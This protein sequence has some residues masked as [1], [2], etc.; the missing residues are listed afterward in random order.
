MIG[1]ACFAA[2]TLLAARS[3]PQFGGSNLHSGGLNNFV[4]DRMQKKKFRR[5][6]FCIF[7]VTD[8]LVFVK[9]FSVFFSFEI[10]T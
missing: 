5:W 6:F 9:T 4:P 2:V 1:D 8:L 7:A 10:F 3:G